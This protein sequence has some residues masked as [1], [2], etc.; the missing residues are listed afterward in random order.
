[1]KLPELWLSKLLTVVGIL[2]LLLLAI[3]RWIG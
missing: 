1:M 3:I 2:G